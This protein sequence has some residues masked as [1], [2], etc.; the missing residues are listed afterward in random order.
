MAVENKQVKERSVA[1][2]SNSNLAKYLRFSAERVM[3]NVSRKEL[4]EDATLLFLGECKTVFRRS[5]RLFEMLKGTAQVK[6]RASADH[7]RRPAARFAVLDLENNQLGHLLKWKLHVHGHPRGQHRDDLHGNV[8]VNR[9]GRVRGDDYRLR[10]EPD[11]HRV[12]AH[13]E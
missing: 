10:R 3:E 8:P 9:P 13:H 4:I 7:A 2:T 12:H 1:L 11:R 5:S 6:A